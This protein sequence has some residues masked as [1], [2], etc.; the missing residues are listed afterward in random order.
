MKALPHAIRAPCTTARLP[1]I[2]TAAIVATAAIGAAARLDGIEPISI[3]KRKGRGSPRPFLYLAAF[4]AAPPPVSVLTGILLAPVR[5]EHASPPSHVIP[6][7]LEPHCRPGCA[8]RDWCRGRRAEQARC[9][10]GR[11]QVHL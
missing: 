3:R 6:T 1:A 9:D 10:G 2:V 4:Q 7:V 5:R 8:G 11:P